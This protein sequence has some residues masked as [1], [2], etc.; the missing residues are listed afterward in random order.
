MAT[1]LSAHN[2]H[3]SYGHRELSTKVICELELLI[4]ENESIVVTGASGCG[5][6]TLLHLLAGL[7]LPDQ[8]DIQMNGQTI[9][10]MNEGDRCLWRA[11]H[12]GF[13][14]Q[15]HHLLPEF[16]ALENVM[17]PLL[18]RGEATALAR[19]RAERMLGQI[20]LA[21]ELKH[22]RP[23]ELSGGERQ[24]VAVARAMVGHPRLLLAD[25]PTGN[26]DKDNAQR[27][28]ELMLEQQR[29]MNAS[30]LVVSHNLDLLP[31]FNRHLQLLHGQLRPA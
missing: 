1:L 24:R 23:A 13:V 29:Q 22:R 2:L 3:K 18:I 14:Y 19:Q 21:A 20:R 15:F 7:D 11:A 10:R 4:E 8:G 6:T 27:L 12:L 5:K 30:L 28:V 31:Y 26:L 25:E 16:D 17:L 9:N